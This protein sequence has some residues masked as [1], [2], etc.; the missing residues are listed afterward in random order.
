MVPLY[1]GSP[2]LAAGTAWSC[3]P[4]VTKIIIKGNFDTEKS[5]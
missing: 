3:R 5:K 4:P 1:A 2:V